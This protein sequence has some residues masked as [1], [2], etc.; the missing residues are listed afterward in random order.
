M[1]YKK[2]G[3]LHYLDVKKV[4]GPDDGSPYILKYCEE[5]CNPV[6]L[7]FCSVCRSGEFPLLWKVSFIIPVYK[8]KGSA[9]DPRFYC[10]IAVL[11]TL[12]MVFD[13]VIYSKLY[14]HIFPYTV[15]HLGLLMALGLKIVVLLERLL[16]YRL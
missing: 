16:L 1:T 13:H 10:P 7:L 12:A 9:T 4:V 6:C 15:F 8:R 3:V 5:L 2:L 14:R 11:P